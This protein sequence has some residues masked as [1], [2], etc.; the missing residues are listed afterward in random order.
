M[1]GVGPRGRL[2]SLAPMESSGHTHG[3]PEDCQ[4]A[5]APPPESSDL[6]SA[7]P[8]LGPASACRRHQPP[9]TQS[10]QLSLCG[11]NPRFSSGLHP[12]Q[13]T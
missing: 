5:L 3:P 1:A 7:Y 4:G 12:L 2:R 8:G 6:A 9:L 10:A 11:G 13:S